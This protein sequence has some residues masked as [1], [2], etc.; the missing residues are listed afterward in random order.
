MIALNT[1]IQVNGEDLAG[2]DMLTQEITSLSERAEKANK[3]S[4]ASVIPSFVMST[5]RTPR[6]TGSRRRSARPLPGPR[7][8]GNDHKDNRR[9]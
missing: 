8:R 6:C 3:A 2:L 1:S 7:K 4:P 9:L 5:K